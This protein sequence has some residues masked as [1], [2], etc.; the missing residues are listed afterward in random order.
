M[1]E[2]RVVASRRSTVE[3]EELALLEEDEGLDAEEATL[4]ATL[5]KQEDELKVADEAL[6]AVEVVLDEQEARL[7]E[8]RAEA[9][10]PAPPAMLARYDSLRA[11]FGG[12]AIA[13]LVGSRCDGCH[14]TLAQGVL[15]RIRSAPADELVECE[16][17]GRLLVR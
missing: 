11:H 10:A 17:C 15:E 3:D 16:E 6:A 9:A 13:R 5:A 7:R 8:Q 1:A 4:R 2:Q 12:V 14:L